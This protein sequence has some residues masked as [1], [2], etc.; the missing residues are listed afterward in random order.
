M[1]AS[2]QA[3]CKVDDRVRRA[4]FYRASLEST[5]ARCSGRV[6]SL[7]AVRITNI[8]NYSIMYIGISSMAKTVKEDE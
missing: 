5:H 6:Y 7:C 1:V 2:A 3:D 4:L 8:H